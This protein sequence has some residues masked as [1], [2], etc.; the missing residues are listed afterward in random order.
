MPLGGLAAAQSTPSQQV[1]KAERALRLAEILLSLPEAQRRAICLRHMEGLKLEA[2]A[3]EL[4]RSVGSVAGL[5]DRGLRLCAK[6][7]PNSRGVDPLSGGFRREGT[8]P[9]RKFVPSRKFSAPVSP[10]TVETNVPHQA[11]TAFSSL[12]STK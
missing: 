3:E 10:S 6:P 9:R 1:I 4:G 11:G 7:C 5:I 12:Y 2:I 8:I